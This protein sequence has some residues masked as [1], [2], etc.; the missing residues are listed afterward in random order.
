MINMLFDPVQYGDRIY[1]N[2][3]FFSK[4]NRHKFLRC[5][6]PFKNFIAGAELE[7][8]NRTNFDR[9]YKA[10]DVKLQFS[11]KYNFSQIFYRDK[12]IDNGF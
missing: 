7:Y 2:N 5:R 1:Y 3:R 6:S 8:G 11:F 9:S 10:N 12:K 4:N